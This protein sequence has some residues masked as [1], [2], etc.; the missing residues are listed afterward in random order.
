MFSYTVK[1]YKEIII[2]RLQAAEITINDKKLVILNIYGP[3]TDDFTHFNT[4]EK[5]LKDNTDKTLII[6]GDFNTVL[7]LKLIKR[8]GVQIHINYVED[9]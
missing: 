6:G 1:E 9:I 5:Y 4:L 3:N 2:G 8:T 7:D